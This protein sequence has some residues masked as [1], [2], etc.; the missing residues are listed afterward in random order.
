MSTLDL[1]VTDAVGLIQ[2]RGDFLLHGKRDIQRDR[3]DA[4]DEQLTHGSVDAG[5]DNALAQRIAEEPAPADAD[6]VRHDARLAGV[7][8][9]IHTAAAQTADDF[10]LQQSGA[11]SSRSGITF[12]AEGLGG[13]P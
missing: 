11:F 10:S 9:D 1:T 8:V 4:I 2:T 5:S 3:C 7:V 6:I 12:E 13:F